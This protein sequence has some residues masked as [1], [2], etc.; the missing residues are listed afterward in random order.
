MNEEF[1]VI[2]SNGFIGKH[3]CKAINPKYYTSRQEAPYH[4]DL[5]NPSLDG[6][7]TKSLRFAI[8]AAACASIPDCEKYPNETY[9]VNVEGTLTLTEQLLEKGIFPILFSSDYVFSGKE[10][11][12][13]EGSHTGPTTTYGKQ[14]EELES[15]IDQV[16]S[17]NHLLLRL[18][19]VYSL[20]T[21]D[22]TLL[23]EMANSLTKGLPIKAAVD[24]IFCPLLIEDLIAMTLKLIEKNHKG[25]FN[26][27]GRDKVSRFQLA[28]KLAAT[29]RVSKAPILP[30]QLNDLNPLISRPGNTSLISDKVY[31]LLGY[32]PI[33]IEHAIRTISN[34]F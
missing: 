27:G 9:Q 19:K 5:K 17:G 25:L 28:E 6:I 21:G 2:G 22:G 7:P 33:S 23:D 18:S 13:L 32:T 4:I 8:I 30:I 34:H 12:Y 26:F 3:F 29:L 20:E 15:R 24:Q 31:H 14:K 11:D 10:G 1:I 16:T